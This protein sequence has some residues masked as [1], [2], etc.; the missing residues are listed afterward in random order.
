MLIGSIQRF[1]DPQAK[2]IL[3][4]ALDEDERARKIAG[5]E[6]QYYVT[7]TPFD[8]K[9]LSHLLDVIGV[10]NQRDSNFLHSTLDGSRWDLIRNFGA[11]LEGNWFRNS[12]LQD[13]SGG[14]AP[15]MNG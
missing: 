14:H 8:K 2:R 9:M 7:L 3:F 11:I 1:D 5:G 15:C 13:V 10:L 12:P 6:Q 4:E